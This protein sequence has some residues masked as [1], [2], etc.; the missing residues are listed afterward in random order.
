M[1]ESL[2][3]YFELKGAVGLFCVIRPEGSRFEK[4]L[5][6][7]PVSRRTL[8]TR[9]DEASELGLVSK[10]F[11]SGDSDVLKLWVPTERGIE[12]YE[13]LLARQ[14]PPRFEKYRDAVREFD[15]E[16]DAFVQYVDRKGDAYLE[17]LDTTA[18]SQGEE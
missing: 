15:R 1:A 4:L 5:S 3:E 12:V 14:I 18:Y 10:E 17:D 11:I 6:E 13:E 16:R 7:L 2:A 8:N 9:L